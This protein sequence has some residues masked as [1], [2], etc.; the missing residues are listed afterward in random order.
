MTNQDLFK[1]VLLLVGAS[2]ILGF[3]VYLI[4][5]MRKEGKKLREEHWKRMSLEK[6]SS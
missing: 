1:I 6:A 4:Y 2:M 3:L 5:D